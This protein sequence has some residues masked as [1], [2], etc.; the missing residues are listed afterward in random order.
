[1]RYDLV[2]AGGGLQSALIA[3]ATLHA[4]PARRIAIIEQDEKL[5][6][7]HHW[8][9]HAGDLPDIAR[10]WAEPLI[11]HT[12]PDYEV[13]FPT[14]TRRLDAPYATIT[15]ERL[16]RVVREVFA[17][18]EHATIICGRRVAQVGAN[19]VVLDDGER[20]EGELVVDA[21]GPQATSPTPN[22][23]YQKFLGLTLRVAGRMPERPIIMDT[24]VPQD[25][26]LRFVYVLPLTADRVLIEDTYYDTSPVL[27]RAALRANILDYA[28]ALGLNVLEVVGEEHGVLPLPLELTVTP[29]FAKPLVAGYAGGWLQPTTGYSFPIAVRLALAL[30]SSDAETAVRELAAHHATQAPFLRR[31]NRWLF[32]GI[33]PEHRWGL[34]AK[35]YRL[36]TDFIARFYAMELGHLERWRIIAGTPPKG[37]RVREIIRAVGE[38]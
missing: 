35:F 11:A 9:F 21:R 22:L 5:G 18:A 27:D 31:L 33:A 15:S 24:R 4:H 34:F 26:G 23:A 6:G 25:R 32:R 10:P 36:P 1:M 12:W 2:L 38:A 17:K 29:T 16:D 14:Y 7:Q 3:L 19:H 28:S 8:S 13:C 37:M 30:A 20:I